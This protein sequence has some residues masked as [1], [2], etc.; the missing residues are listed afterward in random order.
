MCSRETQWS[1]VDR[2]YGLYPAQAAADQTDQSQ[3]QAGL[4]HS[5]LR[6]EYPGLQRSRATLTISLIIFGP[7]KKLVGL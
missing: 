7:P 6:T 5:R 4:P 3:Q 2:D 1:T